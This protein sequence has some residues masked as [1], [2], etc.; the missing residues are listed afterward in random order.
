MSR[1]QA[2]EPGRRRHRNRRLFLF[3][4][5]PIATASTDRSIGQTRRIADPQAARAI[6][7]RQVRITYASAGGYRVVEVLAIGASPS[8]RA[9]G[10]LTLIQLAPRVADVMGIGGDVE[11]S[12]VIYVAPEVLLAPPVPEGGFQVGLAY[13]IPSDAGRIELTAKI[14]TERLL[15]LIDRGGLEI[16]MD[17]ALQPDGM[18]GTPAHPILRYAARDV[19]AG[20][21][22]TI[23][24]RDRRIGWRARLAVLAAACLAAGTAAVLVRRRD[25]SGGPPAPS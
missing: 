17:D 1:S 13:R 15:L 22:I 18:E 10:P 6:R 9:A 16:E 19:E 5:L 2:S 25:R 8:E 12:Q 3:I 4:L 21:P 24:L 7:E 23:D 11:P 14:P 20:T